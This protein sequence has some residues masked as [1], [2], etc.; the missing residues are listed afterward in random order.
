VE[1]L[2][3][4]RNIQKK[5]FQWTTSFNISYN[6]NQILSVAH[7]SLQQGYSSYNT[8]YLHKGE[9]INTLKAIR[10][11][12][13]DAQ[14]GKPQFEKMDYDASGKFIGKEIVND[15]S[16]LYSDA[17]NFQTIGSFQPRFN[18]GMTNTFSYKHF[19]LNI[20][21][22]YAL[23]YTI[24]DNY[25]M[26]DQNFQVGSSQQIALGKKQVMWTHPGQTNATEPML[27]Y[28]SNMYYYGTSKNMHDASNA[29]LR[30]VRLSYDLSET[31]AKKARL[32]GCTF[33]VSGDNLVTIFSPN[34]ISTDPEGPSVGQAQNFGNSVGGQ[35]GAPRRLVVGLQLSF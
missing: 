23:K 15:P 34:V 7:D 24:I 26:L 20:L 4:S 6:R 13:V 29:R 27:Y 18:G 2:I 22:T 28:Q 8:Y 3:Q 5:D 33:Y 31:A 17:R 11:A 9:D 14:T 1:F 35:I 21:I 10:Y 30:T 25:A 16:S 32:A 19:T 12:G